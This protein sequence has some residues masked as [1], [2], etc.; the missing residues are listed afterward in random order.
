MLVEGTPVTH[1]AEKVLGDQG[2]DK[3][4]PSP[5]RPKIRKPSFLTP[6]SVLAAGSRTFVFMRTGSSRGS[7]SIWA[8][9]VGL[10]L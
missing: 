4:Q 1:D 2:S 8:L 3:V 5:S 9:T 7:L 6:G 10:K